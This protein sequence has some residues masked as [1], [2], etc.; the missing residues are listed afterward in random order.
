MNPSA[1]EPV[2]A[3]ADAEWQ[4]RLTPEQYHIARQ[5]GTE[6]PFTGRYHAHKADGRY[7]CAACGNALFDST[8][9]FNSGTGWPSFTTPVAAEAVSE[10]RD[11]S[12]GMIRTEVRCRRCGAHLGHVFPDGPGPGGL[13]YCINSAILDFAARGP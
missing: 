6:P 1:D 10:H 3:L 8:A 13:R 12:H 11:H 9:K 2:Q 4:A 5:C 7:L